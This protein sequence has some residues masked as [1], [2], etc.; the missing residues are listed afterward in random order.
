MIANPLKGMLKDSKGN[1]RTFA[2]IE[3]LVFS[4]RK[5]EDMLLKKLR[6]D[7]T[8]QLKDEKQAEVNRCKVEFDEKMAVIKAD[9]MASSKKKEAEAEKEDTDDDEDE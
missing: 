9:R 5:Q 2:Q 1:K 7:E 3:A 4:R 8:Q 6:A